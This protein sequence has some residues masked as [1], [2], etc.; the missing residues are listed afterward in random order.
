MFKC[1]QPQLGK[2]K[3]LTNMIK[4][5]FKKIQMVKQI[6]LGRDIRSNHSRQYVTKLK[7]CVL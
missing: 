1:M 7:S 6:G 4:K 3:I 5:I 2:I